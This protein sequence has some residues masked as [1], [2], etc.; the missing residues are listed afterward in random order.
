MVS[1][2]LLQIYSK[3]EAR[4]FM[5]RSSSDKTQVMA[6]VSEVRAYCAANADAVNAIKYTRYFKEGYDAWGLLGNDHPLWTEMEPQWYQAHAQRGISFFLNVGEELFRSGKYE[7]GSVAI[8]LLEHFVDQIDAPHI[9]QLALWFDG[10]IRNWAHTDVL[11][12]EIVEPLLVSGVVS[13]EV[14]TP[15]RESAHRYQRRAVPVAMLGLLKTDD[16]PV[17]P[18]LQFLR[19]LMVDPERVVNQGL[20][21]FLRETWKKWPDAVETLLSEFKD[22]APRVIY[23]YATEKMPPERKALFRRARR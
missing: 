15:W 5:P 21:W 19:P 3:R 1:A 6:L 13:Y 4:A 12:S 18:L 7:E 23:Q 14:L 2:I 20:G 10:G 9:L 16:R 22:V 11:C 17:E 8:R